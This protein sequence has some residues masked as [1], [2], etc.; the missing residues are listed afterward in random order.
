MEKYEVCVMHQMF[1]IIEVEAENED[2][3]AEKALDSPLN[4]LDKAI[5]D[6]EYVE[7]VHP[8]Y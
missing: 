3:A 8:V 5:P 2:D 7:W 1:N 6:D 4:D